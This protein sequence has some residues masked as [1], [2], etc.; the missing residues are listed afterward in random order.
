MD[1]IHICKKWLEIIRRVMN[2]TNNI[3]P[4]TVEYDVRFFFVRF[5]FFVHF[6][7]SLSHSFSIFF[8]NVDSGFS[9]VRVSVFINDL[10]GIFHPLFSKC[11]PISCFVINVFVRVCVYMNRSAKT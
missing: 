9:F 11:A 10:A 7:L 5:R 3:I 2:F 1:P 6:S 8:S 4:N